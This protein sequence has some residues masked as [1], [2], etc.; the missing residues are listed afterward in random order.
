MDLGKKYLDYE[1]YKSLGGKTSETPF[2]VLE[3]KARKLIDEPTH[4]RLISMSEHTLEVK[5]CVYELINEIHNYNSLGNKTSESVG[6]YSVSFN[7]PVSKEQKGIYSSIIN[8]YLSNSVLDNGI[9]YLY[10]G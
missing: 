1:S 10:M 7:K 2:N 5:M 9:P 4:G 8:T 3:Y 6:S